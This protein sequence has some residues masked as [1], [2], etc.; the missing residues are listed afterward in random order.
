M[1]NAFTD[2]QNLVDLRVRVLRHNLEWSEELSR[3]QLSLLDSAEVLKRNI[4]GGWLPGTVAVRDL[5][6]LQRCTTK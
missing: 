6:T 4:D 5:M 1:W 3:Q 2:V